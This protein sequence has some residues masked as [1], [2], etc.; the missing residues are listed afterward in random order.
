MRTEVTASPHVAIELVRSFVNTLDLEDGVD[1]L[2]LAWL[3]D[4]RVATRDGEIGPAELDRLRDVREA[5]RELLAAN[6]GAPV[7]VQRAAAV[8]DAAATRSRLAVRFGADGTATLQPGGS[9]GDRATG[10]MLAVVA[11]A[12]GAEGWSRLKA[13]RREDCRWAFVDESR[14][15]SRVWCSMAACGNRAKAGAYRARH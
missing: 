7:D 3:R 14:N 6:A 4:H 13:C 2:G 9:A 10:R 12:I 5:V 1:V 11:T 15:R 8:L